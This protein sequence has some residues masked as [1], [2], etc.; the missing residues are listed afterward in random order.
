M[1]LLMLPLVVEGYYNKL[2]CWLVVSFTERNVTLQW[3]CICHRGAHPAP[4]RKTPSVPKSSWTQICSTHCD[5]RGNLRVELLDIVLVALLQRSGLLVVLGREKRK[6][7]WNSPTLWWS[8]PY[9]PQ[10]LSILELS[11]A[12]ARKNKLFKSLQPQGQQS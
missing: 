12:I 1:L 9:N 4:E 6:H 7:G 11:E 2:H 10:W 8:F 5:R 3:C